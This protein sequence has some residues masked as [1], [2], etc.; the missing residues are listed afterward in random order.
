MF[1]DTND[2]AWKEVKTEHVLQDEWID[3][4]RSAYQFPDGTT[5]EPFYSFS[6]R[7]YAVIVATDEEGKYI[8]VRQFRHGIGKVTT[9]V[10]GRRSGEDRWKRVRQPGMRGGYFECGEEGT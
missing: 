10:P 8:C 4:R 3:F 1:D 9:L 6:R 5:F 2:L 7:D